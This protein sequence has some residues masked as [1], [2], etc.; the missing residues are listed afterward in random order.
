MFEPGIDG[1][2]PVLDQLLVRQFPE[3]L[4]EEA[5]GFDHWNDDGELG[6]VLKRVGLVRDMLFDE[7]TKE[8]GLHSDIVHVLKVVKGYHWDRIEASALRFQSEREKESRVLEGF[9]VK[10]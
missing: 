5:M 3:G 1:G 2:F 7:H 4:G 8:A 9:A 10:P 6:G